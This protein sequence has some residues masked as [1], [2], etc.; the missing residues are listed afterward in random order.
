MV[1]PVALSGGLKPKDGYLHWQ[2]W[3]RRALYP[4]HHLLMGCL[5]CGGVLDRPTV[6]RRLPGAQLHLD[7]PQ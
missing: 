3:Q 7:Q 6:V 1:G 2:M 5:G 4:P